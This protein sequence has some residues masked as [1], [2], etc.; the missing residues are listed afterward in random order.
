MD[1]DPKYPQF[2]GRMTLDDLEK[3]FFL[4]TGSRASFLYII[5]RGFKMFGFWPQ[6]PPILRSDDLGWPRKALFLNHGIKSISL[7]YNL[8]W[9]ENAWI[10]TRN[11]P[12]YPQVQTCKI[13]KSLSGPK[14]QLEVSQA[15]I[16]Q[17]YN[18]IF[19]KEA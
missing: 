17:L 6:I 15:L 11:D 14:L 5:C 12:K 16:G 8:S 19:E 4:I 3:H 2:W 18:E 13:K 9:F 10:L 1:F 7:V